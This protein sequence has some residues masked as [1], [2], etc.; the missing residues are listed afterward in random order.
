[1]AKRRITKASKRRL[2]IFGTLSLFAIFYFIFSLFYNAYTIYDLT[3]EKDKLEEKY[4]ALKEES[5]NLKID[6]EKLNDPDYLANYARENYLYSKEGEYVLQLK[7]ETEQTEEKINIISDNIKK[8]YLIVGLS[9]FMVLV[10]VVII[11]KGKK[12]ASDNK[13][14]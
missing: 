12:R 13:K 4:V 1:M 3:R 14:K 11:K 7:E 6:I 2:T 8:N 5:E 9:V 10:F